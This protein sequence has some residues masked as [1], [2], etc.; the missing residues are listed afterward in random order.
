MNDSQ[1]LLQQLGD[2]NDFLQV[3]YLPATALDDVHRC[4]EL[5]TADCSILR[6]STMRNPAVRLQSELLPVGF[7]QVVRGLQTARH[8]SRYLSLEV[9]VAQ[10]KICWVY[11]C[12]LYTSPSPRD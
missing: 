10:L 1:Q 7:T 6:A 2:D 11:S 12:L 3:S 9:E 4:A 5:M 8:G